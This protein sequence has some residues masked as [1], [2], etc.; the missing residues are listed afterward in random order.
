MAKQHTLE[1]GTVELQRGHPKVLIVCRVCGNPF[2]KS[3]PSDTAAGGGLHEAK[4]AHEAARGCHPREAALCI[5]DCDLCGMLILPVVTT[6][7][8]QGDQYRT[9]WWPHTRAVH[10]YDDSRPKTR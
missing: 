2:F 3:R 9:V 4:R 7:M 5:W 6:S 8:N 10:G 1:G